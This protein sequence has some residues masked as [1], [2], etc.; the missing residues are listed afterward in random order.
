M[1]LFFGQESIET[2]LVIWMCRRR[3]VTVVRKLPTTVKDATKL[4]PAF[5][6][7]KTFNNQMGCNFKLSMRKLIYDEFLA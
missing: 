4:C 7:I 2:V 5:W 3:I 1:K 6:M